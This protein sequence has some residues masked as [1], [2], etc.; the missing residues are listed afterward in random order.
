[1]SVKS[2]AERLIRSF[3]TSAVL[4]RPGAAVRRIDGLLH[5]PEQT[6]GTIPI[7]MNWQSASKLV[8]LGCDAKATVL[9]DSG[10]QEEDFLTVN[11]HRYRVANLQPR[12][13]GGDVVSIDLVLANVHEES[14][15]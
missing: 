1:M 11:G 13:I 4:S 6:V 12:I 2:E 5:G 15:A 8:D 9:P 14:N 3:K 10:V 7:K